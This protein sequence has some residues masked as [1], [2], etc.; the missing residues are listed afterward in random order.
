M[1]LLCA[2]WLI[3][4]VYGDGSLH[5]HHVCILVTMQIPGVLYHCMV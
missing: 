5:A 3:I 2:D 1:F 4:L